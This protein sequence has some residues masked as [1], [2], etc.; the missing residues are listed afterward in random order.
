MDT[1]NVLGSAPEIFETMITTLGL[2]KALKVFV[3]LVATDGQ[4]PQTL[5]PLV[6]S[7]D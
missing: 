1:R 3:Q 6:Q 4:V 2:E 5:L 7:S